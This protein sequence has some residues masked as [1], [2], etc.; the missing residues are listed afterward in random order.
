MEQRVI[1]LVAAHHPRED[2]LQKHCEHYYCD[3]MSVATL[4]KSPAI[5]M[6]T[7]SQAHDEY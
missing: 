5:E 6:V 7:Y 4:K 2:F 3:K 1:K